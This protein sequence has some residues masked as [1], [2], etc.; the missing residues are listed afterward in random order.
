[1]FRQE[2]EAAGI[3]NAVEGPNISAWT[4]ACAWGG[5]RHHD[6]SEKRVREK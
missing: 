2:M 5:Y 1:M 3:A 6:D 4:D